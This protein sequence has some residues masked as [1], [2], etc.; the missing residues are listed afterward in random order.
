MLMSSV[1]GFLL[2]NA[3]FF[4]ISVIFQRTFKTFELYNYQPDYINF[5][6]QRGWKLLSIALSI[7]CISE[8]KS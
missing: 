4:W 8:K 7:M 5:I 6:S 1:Y 3:A 2:T